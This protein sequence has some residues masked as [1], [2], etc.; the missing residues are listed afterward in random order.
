MLNGKN[1]IF[2]GH[3]IDQL[4][5]PVVLVRTATVNSRARSPAT[6]TVTRKMFKYFIYRRVRGTTFGPFEYDVVKHV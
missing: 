3:I 6:N 1:K 4:C 5:W 2:T